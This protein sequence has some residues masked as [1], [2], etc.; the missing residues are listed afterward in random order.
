MATLTAALPAIRKA[1]EQERAVD[2]STVAP[3]VCAT[4]RGRGWCALT[5]T[6]GTPPNASASQSTYT[7]TVCNGTG[8]LPILRALSA[9]DTGEAP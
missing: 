2:W 5:T 9:P 3:P 8:R 7:C 1:W 4:C 6:S